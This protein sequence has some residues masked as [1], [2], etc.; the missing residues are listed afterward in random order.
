MPVDTYKKIVVAVDGSQASLKAFKKAVHVAKRNEAELIIAHVVDTKTISTAETYDQSMINRS[1]TYAS[2]LLNEYKAQA[3]K[4]GLH[5]VE[6]HIDYGSPKVRIPKYVAKS[7]EADLIMCGA[8][9]LN[10]VERFL[11]GSVSENITRYAPCDVLVVRSDDEDEEE[12][13]EDIL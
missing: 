11:I 6:T 5:K 2:K 4:A 9:G 3:Q 10:A 8:T 1:E 12:S 7:F 13:I